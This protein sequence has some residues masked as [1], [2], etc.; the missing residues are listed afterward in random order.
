MEHRDT[1]AHIDSLVAAAL[2]EDVGAG[3]WTTLWTVPPDRF[4]HA[5]IVARAAGV[6]AGVDVATRVFRRL[7]P[8]IEVIAER[9]DGDAVSPGDVVFRIHGPARA[10]L[11]GERTALNFLQRLSGVATLTRRFVDAVA[12]TGVRILDTRKTT[13][14]W[15]ALEKAAVVAGGGHNHRYGLHDM[16]LLKENHIA[17]AGGITAAIARV[18]EAN[19]AGLPVE[20]EVRDLAELEEAIAAGARRILLD[21]MDLD[22]LAAAVRRARELVPGPDDRVVLEASG[23]MRLDRV[24]AVARTGVDDISVGAITHSAPALDLSLLVETE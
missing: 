20:V 8:R 18:R 12:G 17:M 5:T 4:A 22:T 23:T 11:T 21:N 3:D 19:A 10:I 15:R 24:A 2:A 14:G 6:L 16:V 9:G 7:D 1:E 13:P